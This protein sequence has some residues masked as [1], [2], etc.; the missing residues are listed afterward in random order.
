MLLFYHHCFSFKLAFKKS[1]EA[2]ENGSSPIIFAT[3]TVYQDRR[4]AE[5]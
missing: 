4:L 5:Y 3:L 2:K 1:E